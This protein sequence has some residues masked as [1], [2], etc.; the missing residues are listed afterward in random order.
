M[1]RLQAVALAI[2]GLTLS[3]LGLLL[4]IAFAIPALGLNIYGPNPIAFTVEV[5]VVSAVIYL[6]GATMSWFAWAAIGKRGMLRGPA[7]FVMA[8]LI[9]VTT[10]AFDASNAA[11]R[12]LLG[13]TFKFEF[14]TATCANDVVYGT[15]NG[16]IS[17]TPEP[18]S[19][20]MIGG[21][22]LALA[23]LRR[24]VA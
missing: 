18:A 5:E 8:V 12:A 23:I 10:L 2:A 13:A 22:L 19:M 4:G 9:L 1:T 21:G 14:E 6:A 3:G 16:G 15:V 24:K 7:P 20:A 17:T 11:F